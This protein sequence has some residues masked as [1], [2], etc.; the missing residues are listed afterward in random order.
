MALLK[1]LHINKKRNSI[2]KYKHEI[3]QIILRAEINL[4]LMR[5]SHLAGSGTQ[6]FCTSGLPNTTN[7]VSVGFASAS[8]VSFSPLIFPELSLC[9][10]TMLPPVNDSYFHELKEL[11]SR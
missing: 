8:F 11:E 7:S 9:N 3:L 1:S 4:N 10:I 2:E 5:D 6:T